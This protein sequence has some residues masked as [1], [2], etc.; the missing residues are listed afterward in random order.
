MFLMSILALTGIKMLILNWLVVVLLAAFLFGVMVNLFFAYFIAIPAF[1]IMVTGF[2]Y[3][4]FKLIF[5]RTSNK[6]I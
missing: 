2:I 1:L 5:D 6:S 4:A 3:S